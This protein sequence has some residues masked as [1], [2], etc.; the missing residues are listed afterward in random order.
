[1]FTTERERPEMV[2]VVPQSLVVPR[3]FSS[4]PS[5]AAHYIAP[6]LPMTTNVRSGHE[7]GKDL[8]L[9]RVEY[10]TS[11]LVGEI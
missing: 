11:C 4:P 7:R 5:R 2:P 6:G 1:M 10:Y 9:L 3:G 8:V